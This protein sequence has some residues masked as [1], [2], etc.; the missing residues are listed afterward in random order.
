[1]FIQSLLSLEQ[2]LRD[3]IFIPEIIL[4]LFTIPE[5]RRGTSTGCV[6]PLVN[7]LTLGFLCYTWANRDLRSQIWTVY[8]QENLASLRPK[9]CSFYKTKCLPSCDLFILGILIYNLELFLS[10]Y[11]F[12]LSYLKFILFLFLSCIFWRK[13]PYMTHLFKL[14][15]CS[16]HF[17][18]VLGTWHIHMKYYK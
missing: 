17:L 10:F 15:L 5:V 3:V 6:E 2:S 16:A 4:C 8:T 11:L 1:M 12:T 7:I 9:S 14:L 13:G 18:I